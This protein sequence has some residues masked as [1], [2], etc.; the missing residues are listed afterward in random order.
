MDARALTYQTVMRREARA[1]VVFSLLTRSSAYLVLALLAGVLLTLIYGSWPA[2]R[3]FKFG[4][5]THEVWDPVASQFGAVAPL[6]AGL[7]AAF[8]NKLGFV[9]PKLWLNQGAF[10]DI[11]VGS[12]GIY[13]AAPGPDACSGIGAPIGTRIA[14]LFIAAAVAST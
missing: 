4:F 11:T 1:D 7:F 12:N 8:G 9:T 6:Y 3:I 2:L 5:L 10:T 14:P 13:S